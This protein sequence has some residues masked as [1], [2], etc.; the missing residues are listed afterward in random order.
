MRVGPI[1]LELHLIVT[2]RQAAHDVVAL[3]VGFIHAGPHPFVGA[4][5]GDQGDHGV[6]H[7]G[8]AGFGGDATEKHRAARQG[9]GEAGEVLPSRKSDGS[10]GREIRAAV[11]GGQVTVLQAVEA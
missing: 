11:P 2:G 4:G 7:G 10:G 9:I 5:A 6:D 3:S 1:G 8:A